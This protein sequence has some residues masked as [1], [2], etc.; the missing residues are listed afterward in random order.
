MDDLCLEIPDKANVV[1]TVFPMIANCC[2]IEGRKSQ[3]VAHPAQMP[4]TSC[5]AS[6]CCNCNCAGLIRYKA[7]IVMRQR[8]ANNVQL[9]LTSCRLFNAVV[10]LHRQQCTEL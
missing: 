7:A 3:Q 1:I 2:N 9:W 5:S 10:M 4:H 6:Y 8:T